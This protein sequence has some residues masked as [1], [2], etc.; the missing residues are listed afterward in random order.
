MGVHIK[1]LFF[2][3]TTGKQ[4]SAQLESSNFAGRGVPLVLSSPHSLRPERTRQLRFLKVAPLIGV[5]RLED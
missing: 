5:L 2:T 4:T 3:V 1:E